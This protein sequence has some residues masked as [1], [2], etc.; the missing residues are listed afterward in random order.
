MNTS[1]V[2]VR[3]LWLLMFCALLSSSAGAPAAPDG[4]TT[5]PSTVAPAPSPTLAPEQLQP[6][7]RDQELKLLAKARQMQKVAEQGPGD[8]DAR[9]IA[10]MR[11]PQPGVRLTA[12]NL[13][14]DTP[15]PPVIE[16]MLNLCRDDDWW[17]RET[18][19]EKLWRVFG[20][21]HAAL[22]PRCLSLVASPWPE[23]RANVILALA[24]V[25]DERII[26]ALLPMVNDADAHVQAHT[27]KALAAQGGAAAERAIVQAVSTRA[28]HSWVVWYGMDGLAEMKAVDALR[29]LVGSV[30]QRVHGKAV[31]SLLKLG[32][33]DACAPAAA[34]A[35]DPNQAIRTRKQYVAALR[36][37]GYA[38]EL[39]TVPEFARRDVVTPA[40]ATSVPPAYAQRAPWRPRL[41]AV[42]LGAGKVF[43][44]WSVARSGH[45]P[46]RLQRRVGDGEWQALATLP[47]GSFTD[48]DAAIG[49][50]A[51][52]RVG[53]AHGRL[54]HEVSIAPGAETPAADGLVNVIDNARH[55]VT[56][57]LPSPFLT[58]PHDFAGSLKMAIGDLDNDGRIDFV[59][60]QTATRVKRAYSWDGRLLWQRPY[61]RASLATH[62]VRITIADL[63]DDGRSEMVAFEE[64][65]ER[66]WLLVCDG[67]T[68]RI[69]YH[70]DMT[71]FTNRAWERRDKVLL[72]D[73]TGCGREDTI[74]FTHNV[75]GNVQAIA[76][77]A[78]LNHLWTHTSDRAKGH[79][80]RVI[81]LDGDGRD[82]IILGGDCLSADGRL[83]WQMPP[84]T[85]GGHNDFVEA[86]EIDPARPGLE[87]AVAGCDE[88]AA[89]M[90]DWRG[91][92]LWLRH[93]GHAQW[94]V[95]GAFGSAPDNA[96]EVWIRRKFGYDRNWRLSIA[97]ADL[98]PPPVDRFLCTIDWDG[99]LANGREVLLRNGA[100]YSPSTGKQ[101]FKTALNGRMRAADV[102]GDSR[103]EIIAVNAWQR[104]IEVYTNPTVNP[105][106]AP[107]RWDVGYWRYLSPDKKPYGRDYVNP[108]S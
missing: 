73:R 74:V 97:G 28:P 84:C 65:G 102:V 22:V 48:S 106:P 49:K 23:V 89:W 93:T 99:D 60:G 81:D 107:D 68:G 70:V 96:P 51:C 27:L 18:A 4:P 32:Q 11:D 33:H 47:S 7:D 2:A 57:R 53:D 92:L 56:A 35:R 29:R 31:S 46:Y 17:V 59:V 1:R 85:G 64:G 19:G 103:E 24:N 66:K 83:L 12:V 15:S 69:K 95:A 40:P 87:I 3:S 39:P 63:D 55:P 34:I 30:N 72:V 71:R 100:V 77:D 82:E 13:V 54:S 105:H 76:F 26:P 91:Q 79:K 10:W 58:S 41:C 36:E 43:L 75:Y 108:P 80:A 101:V 38:G 44:G 42:D 67:A 16:A 98:G 52:Y 20:P 62:P 78:R 14:P 5:F 45:Q 37:T 9:L 94:L 8:L 21:S 104:R 86:A 88:N 50:S 25:R 61:S 90:L 6:H